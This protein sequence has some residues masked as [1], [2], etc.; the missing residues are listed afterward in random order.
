MEA[1]NFYGVGKGDRLIDPLFYPKAIQ[2]FLSEE[3]AQLNSLSSSFNLLVEVGC[4][5][6]RYLE[7]AEKNQK[8]YLGVDVVQ[9]YISAGKERLNELGSSSLKHR[10]VLGRAEEISKLVVLSEWSVSPGRC[11][12]LFPFNSFGNMSKPFLVAKSLSQKNLPFFISSYRTSVRATACRKEYYHNCGYDKLRTHTDKEGVRFTS[13][14]GL[15]TIAYEEIFMQ[16]LFR[17]VGVN[18]R[19]VP[20]SEIGMAYMRDQQTR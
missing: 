8:H 1:K 9:R 6:G 20:F 2:L 3:E 4:M 15:N 18:A 17:S 7:W 12:L 11:L 10:F 19:S 13:S 14:D 16:R 5:H